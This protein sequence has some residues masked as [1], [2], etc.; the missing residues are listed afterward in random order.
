[1]KLINHLQCKIKFAKIVP[2]QNQVAALP[3]YQGMEIDLNLPP[4]K[5]KRKNGRPP[6]KAQSQTALSSVCLAE[7]FN[8]DDSFFQDEKDNLEIL[9]QTLLDNLC[10][11]ISDDNP[12]APWLTELET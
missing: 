10:A 5:L 12:S 9:Q 11:L 1:M 3:T 7:I 6:K 8:F 4:T 2:F